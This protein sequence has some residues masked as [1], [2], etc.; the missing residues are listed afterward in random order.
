MELDDNLLLRIF[1][2][3]DTRDL[4]CSAALVCKHWKDL[5]FT[6][7]HR[8]YPSGLYE[9]LQSSMIPQEHLISPLCAYRCLC[10]LNLLKSVDVNGNKDDL[11]EA[12][13]LDI[14]NWNG[15]G[16]GDIRYE[17]C[18]LLLASPDDY[19]ENVKEPT[20]VPLTEESGRQFIKLSAE[21]NGTFEAVMK[22]HLIQRFM[23]RGFTQ[24]TSAKIIELCPELKLHFVGLQ[25]FTE[26][27]SKISVKITV[28][29]HDESNTEPLC[30]KTVESQN[31]QK[32]RALK[33]NMSLSGYPRESRILNISI[34]GYLSDAKIIP[35]IAI[36]KLATVKD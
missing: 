27:S 26:S 25:H 35:Y 11:R 4:I 2:K 30:V 7:H 3:L 29:L 13:L 16:T 10:E 8:G 21:S 6:G 12:N 14:W 24:E 5:A 31:D 34:H 36:M 1:E 19:N 18:T 28:S 33:L 17:L 22:V 15:R 32:S 20:T 9:I 23:E